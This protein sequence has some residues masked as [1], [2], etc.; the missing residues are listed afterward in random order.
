MRC[1]SSTLQLCPNSVSNTFQLCSQ[2]NLGD[3][4]FVDLSAGGGGG[5]GASGGSTSDQ[6]GEL[7]LLTV[8]M[9]EFYLYF[10]S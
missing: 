5:G 3:S 8:L 10:V 9:L 6:S 4:T 2:T 1:R 7:C